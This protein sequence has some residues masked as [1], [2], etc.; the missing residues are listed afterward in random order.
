MA[1]STQKPSQQIFC[2]VRQV[3]VKEAPEERVRQK[4][5]DMMVDQLGYPRGIIAVEQELGCL[6][7]LSETLQSVPK[8]RV[9]MVVSGKGIHPDHGLYPLLLV[10]CKAVPLSKRVIEQVVGYNFHVRAF[11]ICVANEKEIRTGWYDKE[12]GGYKFVRGLP[13]F[14]ELMERV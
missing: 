4:L 5:I 6:P 10:E 13:S 8:R 12:M 1:L 2:S 9:D 11:F 3:W 14:T 7:H